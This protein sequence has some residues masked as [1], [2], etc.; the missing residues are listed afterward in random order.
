MIL[1]VYASHFNNN[2]MNNTGRHA[3]VSRVS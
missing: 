3:S 2:S 1:Y